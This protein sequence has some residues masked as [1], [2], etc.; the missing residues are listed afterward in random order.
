[1]KEIKIRITREANI[2]NAIKVWESNQN[3]DSFGCDFER[4]GDIE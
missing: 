2:E 3:K 4:R 1:M